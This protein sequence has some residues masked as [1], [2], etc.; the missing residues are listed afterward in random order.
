MFIHLK[1][2]QHKTNELGNE[3]SVTE[4]TEG[5]VSWGDYIPV[6]QVEVGKKMSEKEDFSLD[7][8]SNKFFR[9]HARPVSE[10][11]CGLAKGPGMRKKM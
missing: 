2:P 7:F 3:L 1:I 9:A 5:T 8:S 6:E 4:G 11:T 10:A